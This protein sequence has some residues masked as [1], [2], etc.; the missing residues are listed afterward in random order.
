ME[1]VLASAQWIGVLGYTPN[2]YVETSFRTVKFD[3]DVW[4]SN[5]V[6]DCGY[7]GFGRESL[8]KKYKTPPT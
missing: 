6:F 7:F 2:A 5:G 3:L 8:M 1:V 4:P